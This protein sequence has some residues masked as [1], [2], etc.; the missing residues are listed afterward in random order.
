MDLYE[1][2]ET[3]LGRTIMKTPGRFFA[4]LIVLIVCIFVFANHALMLFPLL[5]ALVMGL[6]LFVVSILHAFTIAN[7]PEK[8]APKFCDYC[9]HVLPEN[10]VP[11]E[12]KVRALSREFEEQEDPIY[13]W[14]QAHQ[15]LARRYGGEFVAITTKEHTNPYSLLDHD[16]SFGA[17]YHRV[18]PTPEEAQRTDFVI[19]RL[20]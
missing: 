7:N 13:I 2:T 10:F 8:Y 11:K 12:D 14:M 19:G 9:D 20:P 5:L 1:K 4:F 3:F 16:V 6:Y 15:K 17:L 18:H